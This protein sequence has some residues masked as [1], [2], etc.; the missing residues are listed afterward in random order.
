MQNYTL[1]DTTPYEDYADVVDNSGLFRFLGL[2][3]FI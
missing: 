2:S 3:I 1:K